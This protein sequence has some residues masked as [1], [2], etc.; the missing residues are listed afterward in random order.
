MEKRENFGR[1]LGESFAR[2]LLEEETDKK[3]VG[4]F[5]I[6]AI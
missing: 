6:N 1:H 3:I 4:I 2:V 5:A